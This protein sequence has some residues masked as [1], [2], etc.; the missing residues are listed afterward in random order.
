MMPLLHRSLGQTFRALLWSADARD[1]GS[2]RAVDYPSTKDW[3]NASFVITTAAAVHSCLKQ[4]QASW[5]NQ[6]QE[7]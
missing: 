7:E 4:A 5:D 1:G 3:A 2:A 6:D